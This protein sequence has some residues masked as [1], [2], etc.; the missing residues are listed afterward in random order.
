MLHDQAALVEHLLRVL[1]V[2][3]PA[4]AV[5]V[6]RRRHA[7][8]RKLGRATPK[9]ALVQAGV[10]CPLV[11][12]AVGRCPA[13]RRTLDVAAHIGSRLVAG[14]GRQQAQFRGRSESAVRALHVQGAARAERVARAP[15][16][17][18]STGDGDREEI[19]GCKCRE[20]SRFY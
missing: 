10:A 12:L 7:V 16:G 8:C 20:I 5:L 15:S 9:R 19:V 2:H 3:A 14:P 11:L 4:S 17:S 6:Q 1:L 18:V 13:L